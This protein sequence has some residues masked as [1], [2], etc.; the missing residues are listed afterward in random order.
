VLYDLGYVS[1]SEP[2]R[3]LINQGYIQAYAYRDERGFPVPAEEVVERDG[4]FFYN[5]KPVRQELGKM[6]KSLK[7]VVTPDEMCAA[8]GAD[9]FRVYEMSMG[10]LEVSRPW[11]TR[12]VVGSFRFLQRVWRNLVD[13]NTGE[14][15]VVDRPADEDTRRLLHRVIDAVRDDLEG[16]RFNTAIAK[17]IEL[18]NRLTQVSKDGA[19][20]EVAEPLVLMLAPFA[21]HMAEE[22]WRKLGHEDTVAYAEFPVA[23]PDLVKGET[24]VYPVQ[25]NGKVRSRIEVPVDAD[26]ETVKATALADEKVVAHLAGA[27]PRKVIV[28]PERMVSIVR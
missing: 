28:V 1:S 15:R 16:L 11:E 7:N 26:T 5:G 2:F 12:A 9:T 14:C 27:E 24:V 3:R 22:L 13:E 6:G 21:P 10:P 19:P 4:Q 17:L 20:R 25:I 18:N 8:Y 23:D